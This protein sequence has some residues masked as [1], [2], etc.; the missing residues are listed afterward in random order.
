MANKTTGT[1]IHISSLNRTVNPL[2]LRN[3]SILSGET[4]IGVHGKKYR[5]LVKGDSR[6]I[7]LPPFVR[8]SNIPWLAVRTKKYKKYFHHCLENI[9]SLR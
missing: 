6:A 7:P 4:S 5:S 3:L 1:H 8:A 9:D 2:G